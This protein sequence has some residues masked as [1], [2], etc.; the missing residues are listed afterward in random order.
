MGLTMEEGTIVEWFVEEGQEVKIGERFF[1]VA[2]DKISNEIEAEVGGTLLK[3]LVA[4]DCDALVQAPVAIVGEAGE[5]ISALMAET[6]TAPAEAPAEAAAAVAEAP[7]VAAAT[8]TRAPGEYVLASPL[9]KKMAKEM[10]VDL[11]MVAGTG[12]DGRVV[13]KDVIAAGSVKAS[14]M[15]KVVAGELG[16]NI[17]NIQKDGRIMKDD[18]QKYYRNSRIEDLAEPSDEVEKM[19][20]M[21]KV[22][23]KRMSESWNMAPAVTYDISINMTKLMAMKKELKPFAKITYTDLIVKVLSRVLLKHKALNC[24][25]SGNDIIYRNYVNMG[26]AVATDTGLLVPVVKYSNI[27]SL[28]DVSAEIKELAEKGRTNQLGA[29]ALQ[30]GTFTVSNMGMYEVESFSPIINQPETAILGICGI[31]NTPVVN[32]AMEIVIEPLMKLCLTADHRVVDGAVAA[33][34]LK[35]LKE[36]LENPAVLLI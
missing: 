32:D 1:E 9:A 35:D 25:I 24:S 20:R 8:S 13:E 16:V 6:G 17:A 7:A 18:V 21:R 31:K 23:A 28:G 11:S 33:M 19:S 12:P 10:G 4:Q 27:K 26:V 30:G 2:T 5:D 34:F 15:A 29:D 22:V 14:A 3:I 36:H